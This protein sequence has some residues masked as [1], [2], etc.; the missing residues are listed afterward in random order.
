MQKDFSFYFDY[1]INS[2]LPFNNSNI[3]NISTVY[4]NSYIL[5]SCSKERINCDRC[6]NSTYSFESGCTLCI[7]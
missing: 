3:R 7:S 1:G 2:R 4:D 5:L 6:T